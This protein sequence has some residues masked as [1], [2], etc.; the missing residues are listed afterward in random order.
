MPLL[1][2]LAA[3]SAGNGAGLD[4]NGQPV[5][6]GPPDGQ[7][8]PSG[9]PADSD[10]Q[11]IQDTV[12][13]P[14]CTQC[15]VGAN[16]PQGM[17]LDAAN[18]YAMIV[19]VDSKEVPGL[20]RIDP[21]NPDQSYLVQKI[22]GTAAVGGRMPLGQAPLPQ[23]RIDLIR[24]WVAAG[25]PPASSVAPD[26]LTV[27][28]VIPAPGELAAAGLAKL[29]V[30]FARDVDATLAASGTFEVR[31]GFDQVVPVAAAQVPQGRPNVV[32]VTLARALPAGS[33]QL[34]VRGQGPVALADNAGH[35]LDGD[36]DGKAGGD[37]LMS[38]DVSAGA[39]R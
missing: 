35:V 39:S 6:G 29:T 7:P 9:A 12:F 27:T 26:G 10:F 30:I 2:A 32:E 34:R 13:T 31:D 4:Q 23:D 38:F 36:A 11:E 8:P 24:S 20:K 28:S 21:G 18:S 5:A 37:F 19:N 15:H 22:S 3:C 14:I 16:A 1:F 33:Y 25:A 17:R